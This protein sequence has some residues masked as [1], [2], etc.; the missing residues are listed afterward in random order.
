MAFLTA[1]GRDESPDYQNMKF[2][3]HVSSGSEFRE[4]GG[5][6]GRGHQPQARCRE[7]LLTNPREFYLVACYL[8]PF[9][10]AG[11]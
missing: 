6:V 10:N 11:D 5:D 9:L 1:V 3:L 7:V 4:E 2:A 8:S